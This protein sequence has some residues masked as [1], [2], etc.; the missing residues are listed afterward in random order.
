VKI[1]K[2]IL[3]SIGIIVLGVIVDITCV[4]TINRPIFAVRED[5]GDSI[6]VIY[7]GLFYD[8]YNC[9]EYSMPQIKSKGDKIACSTIRINL[10]K[11]TNIIDKT[12]D[13]KN[14]VCAEALESFY[15][16]D[17]YT[18][19]WPCIKNQYMIVKYQSGYEETISTALKYGTITINE[20]DI[21]NIKYIKGSK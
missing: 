14:F 8:T 12:K 13:K 5:N 10:G 18:Y 21:S 4:F 1:L 16:D 9:A 19:Y 15:E 3:I 2:I 17:K 11:I 7:R 20:L 6:N